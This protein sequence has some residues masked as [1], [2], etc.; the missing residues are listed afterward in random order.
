MIKIKQA[1][2]LT[3]A[4]KLQDCPPED[5]AE[6]AFLGRSN[7]GKSTFINLM[8][9]HA[10][11][12]KCSSTPGKTQLINFFLMRCEHEGREF[13]FRFV[14]L[15]GFGYAKVCKDLKREWE[16]NLWDFLQYRSSIKLFLHLI[17][18]RHVDLPI[19][20]SVS[21]ILEQRCHGDQSVLKIYTKCDKL[22]ANERTRLA[23]RGL[24]MSTDSTLLRSSQGGR[25]RVMQ[26]IFKRVFDYEYHL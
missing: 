21:Q 25:E 16:K 13:F 26:E 3:S 18:C 8:A 19:D 4:K 5:L 24:L 17:D 9:N 15:P 10:K 11:L 12:A 20:E 14:D 6:I 1:T 23:Q 7:V 2:F 22:N